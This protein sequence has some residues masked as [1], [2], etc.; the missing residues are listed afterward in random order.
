[1]SLS[2]ASLTP[3]SALTGNSNED[4]WVVYQGG[5]GP[6]QGKNIVLVAGDEEYRSE[7]A[8]PMLGK[9][10]ATHHG[11]RCTVLF[12][13]DREDGT[14]DPNEQTHIPG[15]ENIAAADM[16]VLFLRFRE[17]PDDDMRRIV[18]HL[19][20]GKP[21]LGIR[22]STHAFDYRRDKG[23]PYAKYGLRA[24][25]W[26]G[27]FGKQILGETWV[28]H[29]GDHG[30]QATRGV[31]NGEVA[32]HPILRGVKNAFG[33][34]DVYAVRA[35]PDDATVL[36]WGQV[37]SGMEP[38]SPPVAGGKNDP[39]MPIVWTREIACEGSE[40]SMRTICSTIG[41]SVDLTSEGVRRTLVNACYWGLEL[42]DKIPTKSNVDIVGR[43]EP[44][45]FGFG[46]FTKG[47][48]ASEH[49]V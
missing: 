15:L 45:F 14:I 32:D 28:A 16:L 44:T 46:K 6:G 34:T 13:T 26:P 7:E 10:L 29:H 8:L 27:G 48:K 9:V 20:A 42:E 24:A 1:M 17:L 47:V 12:S 37:L 21:I 2:N 41:A 18:D 43:Y 3:A 49:L 11:F 36:L 5:E 23:S 31:V 39:M 38:D 19:E 22:T 4:P 40:A 33:P 25:E 35:L 30:S